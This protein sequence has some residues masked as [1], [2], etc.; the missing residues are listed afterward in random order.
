[1]NQPLN[2]KPQLSNRR[3]VFGTVILIV[4]FLSPLLIPW[5][6]ST[7]W[8]VGLKSFLSG[9][10]AFGIPEIFM[11]IAI[12]VM[13]KPGYEF[14]KEKIAK[15]IQ[16]FLPPDAVSQTRYRFGLTLFSIPILFGFLAPYLGHFFKGL[17]DVPI[18]WY[19]GLDLVFVVSLF[20]L[21]G[22]FWDKL[23]GLFDHE[24]RISK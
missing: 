2:D 24:A 22:D 5:V 17:H 1:M 9:F 16:P 10:L 13:G 23:S 19:L 15:F 11:L 20:V 12:A 8:S 14:F 7:D 18:S 6:T 21:G 4:G 3:L